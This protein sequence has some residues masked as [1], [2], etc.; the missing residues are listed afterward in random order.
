MSAPGSGYSLPPSAQSSAAPTPSSSASPYP[1]PQHPSPVAAAAATALAPRL[2]TPMDDDSSQDGHSDQQSEKEQDEEDDDDAEFEMD[3]EPESPPVR[4]PGF[5][6][7]QKARGGRRLE[8]PDNL[9]ADL[10]GL[11]RS[12]SRARAACFSVASLELTV[13]CVDIGTR[14]ACSG[15]GK[16]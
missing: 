11:R 3:D 1:H 13:V 8:L 10:Y 7:K 12:V 6:A 16:T 2:D 14:F 15:Q 4:A 5:A 9:D